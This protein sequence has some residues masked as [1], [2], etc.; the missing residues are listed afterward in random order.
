MSKFD[1]KMIEML[2]NSAD[3]RYVLSEIE[4]WA[5][6]DNSVVASWIVTARA[7]FPYNFDLQVN[8]FHLSYFW[9]LLS[10]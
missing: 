4:G 7:L 1:A 9:D 10:Y 5:E 6:K 2:N 3:E 8:Y